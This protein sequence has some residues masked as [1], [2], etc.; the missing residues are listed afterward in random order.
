M[1][2]TSAVAAARISPAQA[3]HLKRTDPP[4]R[5]VRVLRIQRI[6]AALEAGRSE[7]SIAKDEQVPVEHVQ[8]VRQL[9][10]RKRHSLTIAFGPALETYIAAVKHL[11]AD[12]EDSAFEELIE[13]AA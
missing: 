11:H 2:A 1:H 6:V 9:E 13:D 5:R 4:N 12:I 3:A 8:R 10:L 7:Y